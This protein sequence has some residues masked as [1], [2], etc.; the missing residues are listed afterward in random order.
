[1]WNVR[2]LAGHLAYWTEWAGRR[3]PELARGLAMEKLDLNKINDEVYR[4]NR[5][6]SFVMLLPQLRTAED[7]ALAAIGRIPGDQL[8]EGAARECIDFAL[9]E[10][11]D[12]HWPGLKAAVERL[13]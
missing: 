3:V 11:Y 6:M 1:R 7:A 10:H 12:K 4:K 9:I 13:E 2:D 8:I 5:R